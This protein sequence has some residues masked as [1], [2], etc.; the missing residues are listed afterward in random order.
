MICKDT[1]KYV[2]NTENDDNSPLLREIRSR[3]RRRPRKMDPSDIHDNGTQ[4]RRRR[5]LEG[6]PHRIV[7]LVPHRRSLKSSAIKIWEEFD[8]SRVKNAKNDGLI[9]HRH[10]HPDE[11]NNS[12]LRNRNDESA[13]NYDPARGKS[14]AWRQPLEGETKECR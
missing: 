7:P 11:C 9:N 2:K 14:N 4:S 13:K 5:P 6:L 3:A 1:R 10:T 8:G 12:H